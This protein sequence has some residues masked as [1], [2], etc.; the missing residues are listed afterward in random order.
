MDAREGVGGGS[1]AFDRGHAAPVYS[2]PMAGRPDPEGK[3]TS[4]RKPVKARPRPELDRE[5]LVEDIS[6]R[7]S[8]T[9]KYLGR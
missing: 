6:K 5:A 2:L 9:L 1:F 3:K 8:K 7:F 4:Q